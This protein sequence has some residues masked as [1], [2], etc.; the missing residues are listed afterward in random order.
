MPKKKNVKWTEPLAI[1]HVE[2]HPDLLSIPTFVLF[3]QKDELQMSRAE[4]RKEDRVEAQKDFERWLS[5]QT[6]PRAAPPKKQAQN[7]ESLAP[8]DDKER[9]AVNVR[10]QVQNG[11]PRGISRPS[12]DGFRPRAGQRPSGPHGAVQPKAWNSQRG[13]QRAATVADNSPP[14]QRAMTMADSLNPANY[15]DD[16]SPTAGGPVAGR[17]PTRKT[18]TPRPGVNGRPK[19]PTPRPGSSGSA[20]RRRPPSAR[21]ENG[22]R[23]MNGRPPSAGS[24]SQQRPPSTRT[25]TTTSK[26]KTPRATPRR[27]RP[28]SAPVPVS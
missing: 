16:G 5:D 19:T 15:A 23:T 27:E 1:S 2:A 8:V 17:S 20:Q 18:P 26:R 21:K 9:S 10:T 11:G 7:E 3:V 4:V 14:R 12:S 28:P 6:A 22:T 13:P 25:A 24:A